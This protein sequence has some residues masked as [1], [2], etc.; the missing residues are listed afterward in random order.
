MLPKFFILFIIVPVIELVLLFQVGA[1]IG[2]P[3]TLGIII[4][5]A[6]IGVRLTRAQGAHNMQRARTAMNEGRMPHQE[7]LDG[8]MIIIA[9]V[10]LITPGLL[11]DALGFTLLFP[12]L[13]AKL[14]KR[15][16]KSFNKR[17]QVVGRPA[18]G[19]RDDE[20]DDDSVIEAEIIED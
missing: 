5:T 13:R 16:A 18:N 15:L 20:V 8:M 17:V 9:G 3:A 4:V 14:R 6:I 12:S 10:L 11:T 19:Q 1:R 7:V 2:L